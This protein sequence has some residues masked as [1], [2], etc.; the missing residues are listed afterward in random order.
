MV[1]RA[2]LQVRINSYSSGLLSRKEL[3][4]QCARLTHEQKVMMI[5][6]CNDQNVLLR[7]VAPQSTLWTSCCCRQWETF[8]K[9]CPATHHT[10]VSSTW[11]RQQTWARWWTCLPALSSCRQTRLLTTSRM[12]WWH[13]VTIIS[14]KKLLFAAGCCSIRR[15]SRLCKR[16]CGAT[17]VE[18]GWFYH[19]A[20]ADTHCTMIIMMTIIIITMMIIIIVTM[21]NQLWWWSS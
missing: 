17:F 16:D 8:W 7:C 1:K 11:S 21:I 12:R 4:A 15:R 9:C 10:P 19:D 18:G 20:D 14:K 3:T 6:H 2:I 13:W 5:C